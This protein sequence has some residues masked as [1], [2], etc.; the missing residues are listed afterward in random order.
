MT[1]LRLRLGFVPSGFLDISLPDRHPIVCLYSYKF[2]NY[3]G[4]TDQLVSQCCN[5]LFVSIGL[6]IRVAE[7]VRILLAG[8]CLRRVPFVRIIYYGAMQAIATQTSVMKSMV[9]LSLT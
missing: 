3:A 8:V 2:Y 9:L 1:R 6:S 5:R 7:V 4:Q